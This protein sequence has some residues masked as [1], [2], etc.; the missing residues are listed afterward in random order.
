MIV[1]ILIV[2]IGGQAV[3]RDCDTNLCFSEKAKCERVAQRL[4]YRP[5]A[6]EI[7]AWCEVA[8]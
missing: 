7:F 8:K 5:E 3:S 1:F 4:N 2:S 6:P